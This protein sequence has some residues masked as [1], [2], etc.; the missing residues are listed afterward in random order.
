MIKSIFLNKIKIGKNS[1]ATNNLSQKKDSLL[2]TFTYIGGLFM[3]LSISLPAYINSSFLKDFI[4]EKGV[5]AFYIAGSLVAIIIMFNLI[6]IIQKLGNLN[7]LITLTIISILSLLLVALANSP[8]IIISALIIYYS[9]GFLI[10]YTLDVYLENISEDKKTGSIRGFYLTFF[11][12]AWI[13]SP[14]IAVWLITIGDFTHIYMVSAF[15]LIP[16]ILISSLF[17][18][19][20]KMEINYD[21]TPIWSKFC[22]IWLKRHEQ[23]RNIFNILMID[24]ILN[25]FYAIMV[26]YMPLYLYNHIGLTWQ[27]IGIVFSIMLLPFLLFQLP[28]GKIA[29]RWTGEKEI[30]IVAIFI[31]ALAT[32]FIPFIKTTD[33][34]IWAI[35]LFTSRVGAASWEMMK[36]SYLFKN[37]SALDANIISLSRISSPLAYVIAPALTSL[38]FLL[39]DF[40]YLFI[41][42][43]FVILSAIKFTLALKDTK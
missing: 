42:L 1:S 18:Q 28:L 9:F 23:S 13:I 30:L 8:L 43:V 14:F 33:W 2:R 37:V 26:I 39:F 5:G 11:N 10:R 29:D 15:S 25:F 3:T 20:K 36:E 22:K 31:T 40:K 38:I 41:F 6:N 34:I 17:L 32:V 7:T 21:K 16:L 24:L 27:E 35:I 19:E 12:I 4:G